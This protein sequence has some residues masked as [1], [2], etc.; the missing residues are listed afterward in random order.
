MNDIAKKLTQSK[1]SKD[2]LIKLL[3]VRLADLLLNR[4]NRFIHTAT[5]SKLVKPWRNPHRALKM[6]TLLL[7]VWPRPLL[8][9]LSWTTRTRQAS[10]AK[11]LNTAV[12]LSTAQ[13]QLRE[14]ACI[15]QDVRVCA[16]HCLCHILRICAPESPYTTAQLQVTSPFRHTSFTSAIQNPH[17]LWCAT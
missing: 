17:L 15:S 3:K 9:K 14:L 12:L 2:A 6:A 10:V 1:T 7:I 13:N 4:L 11:G 16:A 8:A 5:C